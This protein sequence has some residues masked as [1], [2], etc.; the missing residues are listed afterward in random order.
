M[1]DVRCE[2]LFVTK[3]YWTLGS[4]ADFFMREFLDRSELAV[5]ASQVDDSPWAGGWLDVRGWRFEVFLQCVHIERGNTSNE[6]SCIRDRSGISDT[7]KLIVR[8]PV[9]N[10]ASFDATERGLQEGLD[11]E[12]DRFLNALETKAFF[13]SHVWDDYP[14]Q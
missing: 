6:I 5:Q 2:R 11:R 8:R 7:Y 3:P 13:K 1:K 14:A 10:D 4:I 12:T 9:Q